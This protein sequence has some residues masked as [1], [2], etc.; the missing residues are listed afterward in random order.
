MTLRGQAFA[1]GEVGLAQGVLD[2]GVADGAPV[3]PFGS[4][5]GRQLLSNAALG[6]QRDGEGFRLGPL[7]SSAAGGPAGSC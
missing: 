5:R 7:P 4:L 3:V 6:L 2:G 1:R